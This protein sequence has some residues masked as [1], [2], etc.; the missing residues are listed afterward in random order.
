MIIFRDRFLS[1]PYQ[2]GNLEICTS[3]LAFIVPE[4][5][6]L[7]PAHLSGEG[8]IFNRIVGPFLG[9]VEKVQNRVQAGLQWFIKGPY[10][11]TLGFAL[12]WR[13][14]YANGPDW[15]LRFTWAGPVTWMVIAAIS[16]HVLLSVLSAERTA[17]DDALAG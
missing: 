16:T 5:N 12:E 6:L 8:R 11:K 7:L 4:I 15:P 9:P 17:P 2:L 3:Y 13:Y 14:D 1:L 10:R